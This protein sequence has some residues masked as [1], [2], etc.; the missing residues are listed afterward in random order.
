MNRTVIIYTVL[1]VVLGGAGYGITQINLSNEVTV[2][3]QKKCDAE[4]LE[5]RERE[6][7]KKYFTNSLKDLDVNDGK[8]F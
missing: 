7:R 1:A 2:I 4:C 3:E 8:G 5:A 6:N